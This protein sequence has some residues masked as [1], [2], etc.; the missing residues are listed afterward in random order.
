[1]GEAGGE[2]TLVSTCNGIAGTSI[3]QPLTAKPIGSVRR[4]AGAGGLG[5]LPVAEGESKTSSFPSSVSSVEDEVDGVSGADLFVGSNE[6]A[7]K[8]IGSVRLLE[9]WTTLDTA[10]A[11]GA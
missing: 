8:V 10:V 5:M 11:T 6:L 2:H 3:R 4:R 1:M 9:A 7:A